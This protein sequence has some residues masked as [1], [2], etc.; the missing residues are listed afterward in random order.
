MGSAGCFFY[1]P[2]WRFFLRLAKTLF[3]LKTKG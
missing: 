1:R 3:C 2:P